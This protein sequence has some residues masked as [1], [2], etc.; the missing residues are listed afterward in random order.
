VEGA[1]SS[2]TDI[3]VK[4]AAA[5]IKKVDLLSLGCA[6]RFERVLLPAKSNPVVPQYW[7]S[8]GVPWPAK[9][10]RASCDV[11]SAFV[12]VAVTLH[13][14]ALTPITDPTTCMAI[15]SSAA[16]VAEF[17]VSEH[18]VPVFGIVHVSAVAEPLTRSVNACVPPVTAASQT[19][20][21]LLNFPADGAANEISPSTSLDSVR[22]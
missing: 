12:S 17:V 21:R 11:P 13:A 9:G 19:T 1:L 8:L 6:H 10:N 3:L 18:P 7:P 4:V 16:Y 14:G 15:W 22:T 2:F 20:K 5:G